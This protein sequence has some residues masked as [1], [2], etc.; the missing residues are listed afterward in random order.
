[1]S[2]EIRFKLKTIIKKVTKSK[3]EKVIQCNIKIKK[4]NQ[5]SNQFLIKNF[6]IHNNLMIINSHSVILIL[7][8]NK[9]IFRKQMMIIIINRKRKK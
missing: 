5:I 4:D 9:I 6:K 7:K 2:K 1:M 3:K 8:G